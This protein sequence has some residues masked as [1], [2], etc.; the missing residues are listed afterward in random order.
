MSILITGGTGFVGLNLA[1]HLLADGEDVILFALC[2]PAPRVTA[3]LE[4]LRGKLMVIEGDVRDG[5]ALYRALAD[6]AD[7]PGHPC[8]GGDGRTGA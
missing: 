7:R 4:S 6:G 8:G 1:E 3:H 5:A 2:G